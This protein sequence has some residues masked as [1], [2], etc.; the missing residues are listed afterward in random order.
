M[1]SFEKNGEEWRELRARVDSIANAVFLV[2]GGALS[3]SITIIL[4]N[5]SAG[6]ITKEV[7]S[8]VTEAWYALLV[9][10]ILFLILKVNMVLHAFLLQFKPD[11]L[12]KHVRLSNG[13]GWLL[14]IFGFL[15]FSWGMYQMVQ[16]AVV[17]VR[18]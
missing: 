11:F 5:K 6:F 8:I 12:N 15:A 18:V 14:G 9:S 17:A 3:L 1:A 10:V 4:S 2:A 13:I 16:A 7:T